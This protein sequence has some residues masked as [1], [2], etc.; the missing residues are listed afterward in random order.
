ME[1][2]IK[3]ESQKKPIVKKSNY[4][5][6][7]I[8]N[9]FGLYQ[10]RLLAALLCKY[11]DHSER[12]NITSVTISE[13]IKEL[14][15]ENSGL[16]ANYIKEA[17][18][19]FHRNSYI[20]I[21]SK[22]EDGAL[23]NGSYVLFHSVEMIE[24]KNLCRFEW[25]EN[26]I[27]MGLL[28]DLKEKF[29]LFSLGEYATLTSRYS[30]VLYEYFKSW[31]HYH[32]DVRVCVPEL[33]AYLNIEDTYKEYREF[34]KILKKSVEE[35]N[36]KTSLKVTFKTE[37]GKNRKVVAFN[38]KILD[39]SEKETKNGYYQNNHK[40]DT[41]AESS[42]LKLTYDDSNNPEFTDEMMQELI[43]RRK[44]ARNAEGDI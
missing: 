13:I 6:Q 41:L 21:D 39:T 43:K 18:F 14:G 29:T 28:G 7:K 12:K 19:E 2:K 22:D 34:A 27:K 35:I 8:I 42:E 15:Y 11:T 36:A 25:N 24:A 33:R 37:I 5:I 10:N 31:Q 3:Q 44:E 38:F 4:L 30:Q 26:L 20:E 40:G 16:T 17:V 23:I 9:K 1:N 32:K